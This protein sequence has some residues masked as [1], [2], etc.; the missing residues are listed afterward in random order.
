MCDTCQKVM[1]KEEFTKR[2]YNDMK[3][4]EYAKRKQKAINDDFVFGIILS[5]QKKKWHIRGIK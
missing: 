2:L 3:A 4:K 1:S 5:I